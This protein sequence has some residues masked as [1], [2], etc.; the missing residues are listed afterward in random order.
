MFPV[1]NPGYNEQ[2]TI[3]LLMEA[4]GQKAPS[5]KYTYGKNNCSDLDPKLIYDI[6]CI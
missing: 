5:D 3:L 6:R 1:F 4:V 2:N